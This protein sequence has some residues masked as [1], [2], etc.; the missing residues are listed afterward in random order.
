MSLMT[1]DGKCACC[2]CPS[3]IDPVRAKLIERVRRQIQSG[4]YDT[5]EKLDACIKKL[6]HVFQTSSSNDV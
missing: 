4:T 2:V 1:K 5:D 3:E 6:L